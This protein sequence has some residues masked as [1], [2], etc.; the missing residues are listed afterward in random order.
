[1]SE[2]HRLKPASQQEM[3]VYC[4]LGEAVCM[5][6]H[7][8][9]ALSHS[10]ALKKAKSR[11]KSEGDQLLGKYRLLTLGRAINAAGE[12][13]LYPEQLLKELKELL[14]ERN[15]LIH[16]SVAYSRDEWDLNINRKELICRIKAVTT[17]SQNLLQLIEEDMI[18]FSEAN[19]V[20]MSR[21]WGQA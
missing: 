1:M 14:S 16:N 15:W 12:S 17:Q 3:A 9:D 19:G 11:L 7:V 5:V 18:E 2:K 20:D 10:I 6:Q 21:K 8:E 13:C 4:F